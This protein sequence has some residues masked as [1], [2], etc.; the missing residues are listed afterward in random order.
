MLY[1]A[2]TKVESNVLTEE[3]IITAF[4]KVKAEFQNGTL[5]GMKEIINLF[6]NQVIVYSDRV[7]VILSYGSDLLKLVA[8]D[9]NRK[10]DALRFHLNGISPNI[11]KSIKKENTTYNNC[12]FSVSTI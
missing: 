2:K 1:E 5:R 8:D 10:A 12:V 9:Y 3:M 4:N 6:V 7:E 11:K